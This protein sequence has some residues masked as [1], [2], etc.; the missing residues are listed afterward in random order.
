M[1]V[2]PNDILHLLNYHMKSPKASSCSDLALMKGLSKYDDFQYIF[3]EYIKLGSSFVFREKRV[4]MK[5]EKLRKRY[6]CK[7][8]ATNKIYLF[9]PLAT[10]EL[11]GQ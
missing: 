11:Y 6:R 9:S 5:M 3:L 8:I 7:E 2:F 1:E 4:F 10:V